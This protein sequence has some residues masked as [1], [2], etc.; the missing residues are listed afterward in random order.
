[1]KMVRRFAWLAALL[2]VGVFTTSAYAAQPPYAATP[3]NP[4]IHK[5][6]EVYYV[7]QHNTF[8]YGSTLTSWLDMG[9]RSV[10]LDIID[11]EDWE[12][13]P[14]GPYVTHDS[15]AG[16]KNCS[17]NPDRLGHCLSD[18]AG[19]LNTHPGQ[20]PV[21]VFIDMKASW[22]PANAWY[23][24]EVYLLDEKVRSILGAQMYTA[25]EL[26]QYATG[27]AYAPGGT[28]LRQAVS[29]AGWP[30]CRAW[31]QAERAALQ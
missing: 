13:D 5:L 14:N 23:S 21:L 28:S 25:N 16:N 10:E 31:P 22:D 9:M 29:T 7:Q 8:D 3:I 17:G 11:R 12:N 4:A 27:S 19:W 26:Y 1:M 20:G 18:I 2:I 24:D 6:H 15:S 30:L